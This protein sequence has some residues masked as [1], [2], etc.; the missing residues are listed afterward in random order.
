MPEFTQIDGRL[1]HGLSRIA[2][3]SGLGAHVDPFM[4][5]NFIWN[6]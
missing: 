6:N 5:N 3:C 1:L 2:A 4:Q